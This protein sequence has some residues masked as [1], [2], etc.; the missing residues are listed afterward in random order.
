MLAGNVTAALVGTELQ[1]TGDIG[2]NNI[3][4]QQLAN[5]DWQVSGIATQINGLN[6]PFT[7]A[8]V[9]DIAI[10]MNGGNDRL[11]VHDGRRIR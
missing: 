11:N 4:V 10:D 3:D 2:N 8:G 7:A 5:G 1:I 9:T 6:T